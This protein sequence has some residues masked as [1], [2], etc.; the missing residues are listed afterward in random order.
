MLGMGKPWRAVPFF[1]T[2]QY[3]VSLHYVG[4]ASR[5][6]EV[7][8][9]GDVGGR[10]FIARYYL[11]GVHLASAAVGRDREMLEEELRF[12][13]RI[14]EAQSGEPPAREPAAA[15]GIECPA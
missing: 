1:W 10:D 2:R 7:L 4:H 6:D 13:R 5:W 12:E 9:E 11:E 8:V 15:A 3:D 14:A